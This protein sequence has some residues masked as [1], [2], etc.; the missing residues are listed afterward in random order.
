[1]GAAGT[2]DELVGLC[3]PAAFVVGVGEAGVA[4][5]SSPPLQPPRSRAASTAAAQDT[6]IMHD[7]GASHVPARRGAEECTRAPPA[8]P[9]R[10]RAYRFGGGERATAAAGA[11]AARLRGRSPR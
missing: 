2:H 5:P 8:S 10:R 9:R 6:R 3:G 1:L 7:D 4:G 11:S